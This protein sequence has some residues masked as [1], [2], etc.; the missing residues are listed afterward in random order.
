MEKEMHY[1]LNYSNLSSPT[2]YFDS[3]NS[4]GTPLHLTKP[5]NTDLDALPDPNLANS[6]SYFSS[7]MLPNNPFKAVAKQAKP[8]ADEAIPEA[9]GKEFV[10]ST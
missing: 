10:D 6:E 5:P 8:E 4:L 1:L 7:R 3:I 9:V 2:F